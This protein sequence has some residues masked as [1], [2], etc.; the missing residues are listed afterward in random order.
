MRQL[1][2]AGCKKVFCEVASGAKINRAQLCRLL[3]QLKDG[4]VRKL[5]VLGGLAEFGRDITAAAWQRPGTGQGA[6]REGAASPS[7]S[8]PAGRNDQT[9]GRGRYADGD[10][11][12]LQH[13]PRDDF[14]A[15]WDAVAVSFPRN[16]L[17]PCFS[18]KKF[19][20]CHIDQPENIARDMS[21]HGR[22]LATLNAANDIFGF[23]DG[24][25]W[26][27]FKVNISGSQIREFYEVQAS[28]WPPGTDW[29][30]MMP[31]PDGRL[32]ALY[33]GAFVRSLR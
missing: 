26:T 15:C 12:Q 29:A 18:G 16:A 20:H 6:W 30:C 14:E 31:S 33:L 25:S 1:T 19:K 8:H 22:N 17:C 21:L 3:D 32:R 11:P 23:S 13:Q 4:D 9:P 24:R 5:A 7:S 10:R 27:D 2:E 28:L